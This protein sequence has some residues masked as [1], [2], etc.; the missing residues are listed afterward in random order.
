MVNRAAAG[1]VDI[2]PPVGVE[3]SGWC[4]GPSRGVNDRL[5]ARVLVLEYETERVPASPWRVVIVTLDLIGLDTGWANRTRDAIGA[6]V[7]GSRNQ[8]ILAA[9]HTHSGPPTMPLRRWGTLDEEYLKQLA[10]SIEALV[11]DVSA[12]VEPVHLEL[13][14]ADA[15]GVA[16]NRRSADGPVDHAVR[17]VHVVGEAGGRPL[18]ILWNYACHPVVGHGDRNL[19]SADLPGAVARGLEP[20]TISLFFLGASGDINPVEFH[21]LSLLDAYGDRLLAAI[22]EPVRRSVVAAERTESG[23]SYG[24]AAVTC[25]LP[26][27]PLPDEYSL[28]QEAA[29]WQEEAERLDGDAKQHSRREDA[30]IKAGWAVEALDRRRSGDVATFVSCQISVNRFAGI[31]LVACPPELFSAT[32]SAIMSLSRGP[33]LLATVAN[34]SLCYIP[35]REAFAEG[36]YETDFSAK[37]YGLY[38]VTDAAAD[39]IVESVRAAIKQITNQTQGAF[40]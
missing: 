21:K 29:R 31:T 6:C 38:Q 3:L 28:E 12:R 33:M 17:A 4:F 18:A 2:T 8:V 1:R 37:V 11:V 7:E 10:Q 32:G 39:L 26:V 24:A 22:K 27:R 13:S 9:S 23:R 34:G 16:V 14:E 5:Y 40:L 15:P 20:E 25:R 19:I 30:L 36:G 35:T